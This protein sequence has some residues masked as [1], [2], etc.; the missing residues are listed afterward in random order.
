MG[1]FFKK[2]VEFFK[3]VGAKIGSFFSKVASAVKAPLC[4]SS[5]V[6]LIGLW[7]FSLI[8]AV[9]RCFHH[10]I[11]YGLVQGCFIIGWIPILIF[12]IKVLF[13]AAKA[14]N[15]TEEK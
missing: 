2:I 11:F 3:S 13:E 8:D 12:V 15:N 10:E 7:L 9:L 1:N 14:K 4:Y 5:I 6:M